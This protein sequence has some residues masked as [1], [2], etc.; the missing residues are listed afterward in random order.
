[1]TDKSP[2]ISEDDLPVE[3]L[4]DHD[5][6]ECMYW[7]FDAMGAKDLAWRKGAAGKHGAAD[8]GRDLEATFHN[9]TP[10]AETTEE[11]WWLDA[12]GR[13]GTL[14][15]NAVM[16]GVLNAL[17]D[18]DLDVF[19]I[20]TNT[21][22]TNP[23]RDWVKELQK[24]HPK[25]RIA[26]W[27]GEDIKRLLNK[28][29]SVV[30]RLFSNALTVQGK[31]DVVS[32][33][34]WNSMRYSDSEW[35]NEIWEERENIEWDYKAAIAV[36][37]SE[38]ANGSLKK[39]P[40]AGT[41]DNEMLTFSLINALSNA[42]YFYKKMTDLGVDEG[43]IVKGLSY[44]LT[45][46]SVIHSPTSLATA[47]DFS[48]MIDED[49]PAPLML[50]NFI[51]R[52]IFDEAMGSLLGDCTSDCD[53]FT[54]SVKQETEEELSVAAHYVIDDKKNNDEDGPKAIL[55]RTDR[56]CKLGLSTENHECPLFNDRIAE[57]S[58]EEIEKYLHIIKTVIEHL[59]ISY[60]R[61]RQESQ[62]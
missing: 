56:P 48:L 20:A 4:R 24:K 33:R 16:H 49:T 38:I 13:K 29:P 6:E 42:M 8:G 41:F 27:C 30:A 25:P 47:I 3:D 50:K 52:P 43:P 54:R 9:L 58:D 51:L 1:M 21:T 61:E 7:L 45:A 17:A 53:I 31:L 39:R 40:W 23:T 18:S 37:M 12:K 11:Y 46:A 2:L 28:Y 19:V 35:I 32:S 10:N 44:L 5:F 15:K 60:C 62:I 34:F 36:V 59:I 22:F 57:C 55:I 26:L 14:E